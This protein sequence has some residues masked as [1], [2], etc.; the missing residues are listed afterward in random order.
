M[1]FHSPLNSGKENITSLI[2][3]YAM[4]NV[5]RNKRGSEKCV[6]LSPSGFGKEEE[7]ERK[8]GSEVR[9]S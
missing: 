4:E 3:E 7:E 1:C 8:A 2:S 9:P 5:L 6:L